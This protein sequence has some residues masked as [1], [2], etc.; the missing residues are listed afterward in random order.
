MLTESLLTDDEHTNVELQSISIS[1]NQRQIRSHQIK[2]QQE[3]SL[4]DKRHSRCNTLQFI[5]LSIIAV[6][7][8]IYGILKLL[9]AKTTPLIRSYV[10]S[11]T[12]YDTPISVAYR[13]YDPSL[14]SYFNI[15]RIYLDDIRQK[16]VYYEAGDVSSIDTDITLYSLLDL[17]EIKSYFYVIKVSYNNTKGTG[18]L[19]IPPSNSTFT[20]E[21]Q[22]NYA[23]WDETYLTND[24]VLS[25]LHPG[26]NMPL[27]MTLATA[28]EITFGIVHVNEYHYY[29][30]D[31]YGIGS[32]FSIAMELSSLH[33]ASPFYSTSFQIALQTTK[34]IDG[35]QLSQYV[36]NLEG[37]ASLFY[38]LYFYCNDS[39]YNV[40]INDYGDDGTNI[41]SIIQLQ[42]NPQYLQEK[43]NT[44]ANKHTDDFLYQQNSKGL[45]EL[46]REEYATYQLPDL[47]S[48]LGGTVSGAAGVIGTVLGL[49]FVGVS[50]KF[51]NINGYAP[52]PSFDH[53]F[54]EQLRRFIKTD[55]SI[56]Q[57]VNDQISIRL[58][59][60]SNS[61]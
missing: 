51:I 6:S 29:V 8:L 23:F 53:E 50:F 59:N 12:T 40:I 33:H 19:I 14:Q 43:D 47:L 9:D 11:I 17:I 20:Q 39:R 35:N 24:Y 1:R 54:Q 56:Q 5:L 30:N 36:T 44:V 61:I 55:A 60:N 26:Y 38:D 7:Y 57:E 28:Y 4:Y 46:V 31:Q 58:S 45:F 15:S 10:E 37:I 21:L 52:Y 2:L 22:I 3:T 34:Y 48:G 49:L 41:C 25:H 13:E 16:F 18:F 32:A 42:F 27:Y